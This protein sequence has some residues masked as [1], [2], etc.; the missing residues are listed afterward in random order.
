M[1]SYR[2]LKH[3]LASLPSESQGK[4]TGM[5]KDCLINIYDRLTRKK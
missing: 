4:K 1:K 3:V 2:H 5:N